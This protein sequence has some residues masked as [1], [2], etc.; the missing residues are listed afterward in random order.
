[1]EYEENS[2]AADET[3]VVANEN[4]DNT[5]KKNL[6]KAEKT[7]G[8]TTAKNLAKV[9]D[10]V[11]KPD[12]TSHDSLTKEATSSIAAEIVMGNDKKAIATDEDYD[13]EMT[14]EEKGPNKES[15]KDGGQI[16][17]GGDGPKEKEGPKERE[18]NPCRD[19]KTIE[20]IREQKHQS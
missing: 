10:K 2:V 8:D 17:A 15:V 5:F 19:E 11:K 12:E 16:D 4:V 1:M 18:N 6:I 20:K 7:V 3:S 14:R 9:G 13:H